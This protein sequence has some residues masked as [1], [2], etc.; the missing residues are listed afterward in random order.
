MPQCRGEAEMN[1]PGEEQEGCK[2]GRQFK[3]R[4]VICESVSI[5]DN[6]Y[7]KHVGFWN[8]IYND[9]TVSSHSHAHLK[10][11]RIIIKV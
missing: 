5:L 6:T 3:F 7:E 1:L 2:N 11:F 4:G 10:R 8:F 9:I